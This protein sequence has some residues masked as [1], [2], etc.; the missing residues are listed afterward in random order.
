MD[1]SHF[2]M[3]ETYV[4]ISLSIGWSLL[5]KTVRYV[6]LLTILCSLMYYNSVQSHI[7]ISD[8]VRGGLLTK[9]R[10]VF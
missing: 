9:D 6:A 5:Q 7:V 4:N 1:T 8:G 3:G 10:N 2:K